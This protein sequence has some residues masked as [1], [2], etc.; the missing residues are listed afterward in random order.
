VR[1]EPAWTLFLTPR[2][3]HN[4]SRRTPWT[5]TELVRA[6]RSMPPARFERATPGIG[7]VGP[8]YLR[9][10]PDSAIPLM[11]RVSRRGSADWSP[12]NPGGSVDHLLALWRQVRGPDERSRHHLVR[13]A[14][15]GCPVCRGTSAPALPWI[16]SDHEPYP[17]HHPLVTPGGM[18]VRRRASPTVAFSRLATRPPSPSPPRGWPSSCTPSRRPP[19]RGPESAPVTGRSCRPPGGATDRRGSALPARPPRES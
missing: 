14:S 7:T 1:A 8:E 6:V 16:S 5:T 2:V 19:Y 17:P 13:E 3:P 9:G 15:A 4:P 18:V 10:P 11:E 12:P